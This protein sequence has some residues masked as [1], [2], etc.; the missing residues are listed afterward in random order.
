MKR[1]ILIGVGI[2]LG[3]AAYFQARGQEPP[4]APAQGPAAQYSATMGKY[5]FTCHN[6]KL[7]T[8]DLI[9]SKEDVSNPD[10]KSVV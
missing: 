9:L 8:A 3:G 10:P 1:T 7:K 6:D 4:S 5:C 2:A